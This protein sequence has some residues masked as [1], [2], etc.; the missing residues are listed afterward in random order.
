MTDA[1]A[2]APAG[3]DHT[4]DSA[5]H[6]PVNYLW[7]FYIL[8]GLTLLSVVADLVGGGFGKLAVAVLVL[9]VACAKATFVMLYFMHLKFEG[10]WKY[11]L[12]APTI[13]LAL[14]IVAALA[15]EFAVDYYEQ[16][17]G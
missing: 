16:S 12:L 17:P 11:A 2:H 5:H 8:C 3:D 6:A 7:V 13:V 9:G 15:A 4:A 14:A 10:R 1:A